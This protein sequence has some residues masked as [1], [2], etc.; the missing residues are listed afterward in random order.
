MSSKMIGSGQE[1]THK[2]E[3]TSAWMKIRTNVRFL[4]GEIMYK[5]QRISYEAKIL[6]KV[7]CIPSQCLRKLG[8]RDTREQC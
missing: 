5:Q 1:Y 7:I 6:S 8:D 4:Q 3:I 2:K